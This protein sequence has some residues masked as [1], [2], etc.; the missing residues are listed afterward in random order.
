[1]APLFN[2]A[3]LHQQPLRQMQ[4]LSISSEDRGAQAFA[5]PVSG[6][7]VRHVQLELA[8]LGI[9]TPPDMS[10]DEEPLPLASSFVP[11]NT[12]GFNPQAR[13]A[14]HSTPG[15]AWGVCKQHSRVLVQGGCCG[16]R[17]SMKH[18]RLCRGQQAGAC[19]LCMDLHK[20]MCM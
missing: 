15:R 12:K 11:R 6:R 17:L 20:S 7:S 3:G 19:F 13:T 5:A 10:D 16:V 18:T 1:M 4:R 2:V 9:C 8:R 14:Q